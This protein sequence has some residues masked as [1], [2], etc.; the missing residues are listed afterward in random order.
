MLSMRCT[1]DGRWLEGPMMSN[2]CR[3]KVGR[4]LEGPAFPTVGWLKLEEGW[5]ALQCE[6]LDGKMLAV[7]FEGPPF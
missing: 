2:S 6:A 4:R 7:G 1:Y 5:K 3:P